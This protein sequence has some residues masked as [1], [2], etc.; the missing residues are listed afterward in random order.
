MEHLN[1]SHNS[2]PGAEPMSVYKHLQIGYVIIVGLGVAVLIASAIGFVTHAGTP[3]V[4]ID[5]ILL[6][7][8][9]LFCTLNI[10][11]ANGRL[12]WRFGPGLIRKSVALSEIEHV[13][14]VP[15]LW[16]HGWGIHLTGHGWLYNVSGWDAV[17]VRLKSGKQFR[18]G[19]DEPQ[20]LV[21]ALQRSIQ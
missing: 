7:S 18:L 11:I 2:K 14:Q 8:A 15:V 4:I 10:E 5:A 6:I 1:V 13:E 19:T 16:W 21:E 3:T 20:R 9:V 17:E 12:G